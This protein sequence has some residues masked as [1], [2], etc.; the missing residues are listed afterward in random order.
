MDFKNNIVSDEEKQWSA[1]LNGE[2]NITDYHGGDEKLNN[3]LTE[4]W[5]ATGTK[6][7]YLSADPD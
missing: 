2:P 1:Y 7:S 5:E 4:I 3:D 6:Y